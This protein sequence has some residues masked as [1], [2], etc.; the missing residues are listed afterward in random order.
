[1]DAGPGSQNLQ[2]GDVRTYVLTIAM[3]LGSQPSVISSHLQETSPSAAHLSDV[4]PIPQAMV[5]RQRVRRR[6]GEIQPKPYDKRATACSYC[7]DHKIVCLRGLNEIC[8]HVYNFLGNFMPTNLCSWL[9][10]VGPGPFHVSLHQGDIEIQ[11]GGD[12]EACTL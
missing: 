9:G 5:P 11:H 10:N 8:R 2:Q 3:K 12:V 4:G 6:V 1:M 7:R